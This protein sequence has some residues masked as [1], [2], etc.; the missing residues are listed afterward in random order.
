MSK[1]SLIKEFIEY[2]KKTNSKFLIPILI[3]LLLF[4]SILFF[5][6]SSVLAPFIYTLF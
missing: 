3:I 5:A 4:G 1:I 6:E 2:S